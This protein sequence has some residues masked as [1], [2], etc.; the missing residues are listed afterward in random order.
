MYM[1]ESENS[2]SHICLSDCVGAYVRVLKAALKLIRDEGLKASANAACQ[3]GQKGRNEMVYIMKWCGEIQ[4][5][6]LLLLLLLYYHYHTMLLSTIYGVLYI[7]LIKIQ[8]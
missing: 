7:F 1:T 2:L 4:P 5:F 3:T 6:Q 8:C